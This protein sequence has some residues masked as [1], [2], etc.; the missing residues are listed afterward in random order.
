MCGEDGSMQARITRSEKHL[1]QL[2]LRATQN[3]IRASVLS[4][5]IHCKVGTDVNR[6]K[7]RGEH[8]ESD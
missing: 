8:S 7:K 4:I 1:T 2:I 5:C 3:P 6:H